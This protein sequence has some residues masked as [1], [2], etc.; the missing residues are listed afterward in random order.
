MLKPAWAWNLK[1]LPLT[2]FGNRFS[3]RNRYERKF[4]AIKEKIKKPL[5]TDEERQSEL[6]GAVRPRIKHCGAQLAEHKYLIGWRYSI[7]LLFY[8][9]IEINI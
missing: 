5:S 9:R 6:A 1:K 8:V 3:R 2:N 7:L 4:S